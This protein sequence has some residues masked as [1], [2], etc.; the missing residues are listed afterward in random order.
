[1]IVRVALVARACRAAP[2]RPPSALITP[3]LR[4]TLRSTCA[5]SIQRR[6]PVPSAWGIETAATAS[7][8]QSQRLSRGVSV[9]P[10]PKPETEAIAPAATATMAIAN[11]VVI[12]ARTSRTSK[13]RDG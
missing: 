10:M 7:L 8:V 13:S 5:R 3:K 9:L 6:S 11:S 1:M 12:A 2:L 4:R